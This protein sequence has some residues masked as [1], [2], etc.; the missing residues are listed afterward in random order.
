[1][2]LACCA[3]WM[4]SLVRV[5]SNSGGA[6]QIQIAAPWARKATRGSVIA[7]HVAR[8]DASLT[9][10]P[11]R[12]RPGDGMAQ[13][14]GTSGRPSTSNGAAATISSSCWIMWAAKSCSESACSGERRATASTIRPAAKHDASQTRIPRP[15]C[16]S[17]SSRSPRA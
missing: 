15:T 9:K 6:C 5:A 14:I 1:M 3:A 10:F 11:I 4:V 16:S 12:R 17:H 2:K 13:I 7:R 8:T